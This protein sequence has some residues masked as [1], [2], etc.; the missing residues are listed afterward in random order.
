[1]AGVLATF[2][3]ITHK[4]KSHMDSQASL[5]RQLRNKNLSLDEQAELRCQLAKQ[6]EDVGQ[7]EAARQVMGEIW[8]RIGER[9]KI[10]GL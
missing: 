1:M 4:G 6:Y 7:H 9:P 5:L 8:Q 3:A 2:I 10:E